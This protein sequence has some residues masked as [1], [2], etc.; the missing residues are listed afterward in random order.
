MFDPL[1]AVPGAGC[2]SPRA[3]SSA[4]APAPAAQRW[5]E[6]EAQQLNSSTEEEAQQL[7]SWVGALLKDL[8]SVAALELRKISY[9]GFLPD[10]KPGLHRIENWYASTP[11]NQI[12]FELRYWK[13]ES[14]QWARNKVSH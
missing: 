4:P 1:E 8:H 3:T 10:R 9:M 5:T 12:N 7:H 2:S 11:T 14:L 13:G 6:E